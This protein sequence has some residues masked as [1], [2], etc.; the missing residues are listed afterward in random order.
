MTEKLKLDLS[1]VLPDVPHESDA[2]VGRLT[3]LLQPEGLEKVHM[4]R[5]NRTI[6]FGLYYDPQRFSA[7][8]VRIGGMMEASA[9]YGTERLRLEYDR[10]MILDSRGPWL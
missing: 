3:E 2:C 6:R 10:E 9:R 8:R 1:L 7:S 5:E 4:V